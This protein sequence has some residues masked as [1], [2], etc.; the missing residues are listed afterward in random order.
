MTVSNTISTTTVDVVSIIEDAF[1]RCRMRPEQLTADMLDMA[2]QTLFLRLSA[3]PQRGLQLW[4]IDDEQIALVAGT[5]SYT[6][7]TGTVD[8][9]KVLYDDG[10]SEV[11]ITRISHDIYA[12]IPDKATQGRPT[13]F[14]L[15][16]QRDAPVMRLWPT[17]SAADNLTVWRKRHIMDVGDYTN[18][19]DIPQRWHDAIIADLAAQL[20]L[21]TPEVEANLVGPLKGMADEAVLLAQREDSDAAPLRFRPNI[22]GYTR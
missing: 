11:E 16:R 17:P 3:L 21:K 9:T 5:A 12:T 18:T 7:P 4:T 20:A 13:M 22:S 19:L 14:W 15:D 1:R 10:S 6:M 8:V 2:R